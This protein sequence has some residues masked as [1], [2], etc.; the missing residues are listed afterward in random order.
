MEL[1]S[2]LEQ[3]IQ[4][5]VLQ[6]N[7][8]REELERVK[9]EYGGHETEIQQLRRRIEDMQSENAALLKERDEIKQQV[10]SILKKLEALA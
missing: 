3:K 6:R 9:T 10:E 4:S 5:V 7:K 1:L 8:L 2:Q